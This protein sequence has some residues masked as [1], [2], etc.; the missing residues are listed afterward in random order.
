MQDSEFEPLLHQANKL[1]DKA[2]ERIEELED[3]IS[4]S[5]AEDIYAILIANDC[6]YHRLIE[7][8]DNELICIDCRIIYHVTEKRCDPLPLTVLSPHLNIFTRKGIMEEM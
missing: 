2:Y 7:K 6:S 4:R 8:S 3:I 1:L 5:K